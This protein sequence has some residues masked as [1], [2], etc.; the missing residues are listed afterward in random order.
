MYVAIASYHTWRKQTDRVTSTIDD[1]LVK[2]NS[3]DI[4]GLQKTNKKE[5]QK[6]ITDIYQHN[7]MLLLTS[8][9]KIIINIATGITWKI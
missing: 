7:G 2:L 8:S 9:Y 3:I 5:Q 4:Q 1:S 6:L